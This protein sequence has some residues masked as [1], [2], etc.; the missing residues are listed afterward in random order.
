MTKEELINQFGK[1]D[2]FNGNYADFID[3]NE[4]SKNDFYHYRLGYELGIKELEARNKLLEE[5]INQAIPWVG[6]YEGIDHDNEWE[7]WIEQAK[8][9][10]GKGQTWAIK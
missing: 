4:M 5:L 3:Q 1:E 10:L 6:F 8:K 7:E 2:R 9:L